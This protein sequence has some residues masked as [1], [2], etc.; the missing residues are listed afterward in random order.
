MKKAVSLILCL[1]LFLGIGSS[2]GTKA[3]EQAIP[4]KADY[5]YA[6]ITYSYEDMPTAWL[7]KYNDGDTLKMYEGQVLSLSYIYSDKWTLKVDGKEYKSSDFGFDPCE[8]DVIK[9]S[10][11]Q[12]GFTKVYALKAGKAELDTDSAKLKIEIYEWAEAI[13]ICENVSLDEEYA[14][15]KAVDKSKGN[16]EG[17]VKITYKT[18]ITNNN[19][20]PLLFQIIKYGIGGQYGFYE[21]EEDTKIDI[22]GDLLSEKFIKIGAGKSK[23]VK[24]SGVAY[25]FEDS[26]W[27]YKVTDKQLNK[28][29][30]GKK[31][32]ID[33]SFVNIPYVMI[34][35]GCIIGFYAV[36]EEE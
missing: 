32:K 22:L 2:V 24:V 27:S 26:T 15:L 6:G 23:A 17:N 20:K 18:I 7:A 9:L 34:Y 14:S 35:D 33:V 3:A 25:T 36:D 13:K 12:Y 30:K 31:V 19:D 11:G 1:A 4:P 8:S 10:Y 16:A 29:K 21:D 28:L 5:I